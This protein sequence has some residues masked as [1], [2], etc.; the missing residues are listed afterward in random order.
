MIP[1]DRANDKR[2]NIDDYLEDLSWFQEVI[3]QLSFYHDPG[4]LKWI[5]VEADYWIDERST[6]LLSTIGKFPP[7]ADR[8]EG[9]T[10]GSRILVYIG[11][12][13]LF[14]P[15]HELIT[16]HNIDI[17]FYKGVAVGTHMSTLFEKWGRPN[18]IADH[19]EDNI[20]IEYTF[21]DLSGELIGA[22]IRVCKET[23]EIG[24][25]RLGVAR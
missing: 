7:F 17:T 14:F 12:D 1:K 2:M 20:L 8:N 15:R 4:L 23:L 3:N 16:D 25:L 6:L 22:T 10:I 11:H 9:A 21:R 24:K 18:T 5:P 19:F 13:A